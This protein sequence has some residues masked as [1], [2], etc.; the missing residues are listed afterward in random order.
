MKDLLHCIIQ[1]ARMRTG[2]KGDRDSNRLFGVGGSGFSVPGKKDSATSTYLTEVV[3]HG[4][5][6]GASI[7]VCLRLGK[8]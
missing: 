1:P 3:V 8:K 6:F 5:I 4:T 7:F 2:C